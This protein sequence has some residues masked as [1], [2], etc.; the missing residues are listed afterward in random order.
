MKWQ[1][2]WRKLELVYHGLRCESDPAVRSVGN[3][4]MCKKCGEDVDDRPHPAPRNWRNEFNAAVEDGVV[5]ARRI[6]HLEVIATAA[7]QKHDL[8]FRRMR[9]IE[10]LLDCPFDQI[11]SNIKALMVRSY[12]NERQVDT[13]TRAIAKGPLHIIPVGDLRDHDMSPE[14]W[15]CPEENPE[16]PNLWSHNSADGREAYERGERKPS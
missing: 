1:L 16:V 2:F 15:C 9:D 12:D 6:M 4:W 3:R 8:I 13:L 14:C 10:E 7:K 11:E 5:K